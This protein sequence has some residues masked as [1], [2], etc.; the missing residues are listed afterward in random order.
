MIILAKHLADSN[1][2]IAFEAPELLAQLALTIAKNACTTRFRSPR[3]AIL[4][5][6]HFDVCARGM[7]MLQKVSWPC[8]ASCSTQLD[9][10]QAHSVFPLLLYTVHQYGES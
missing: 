6:G 5:T 7:P 9:A 4:Q 3:H 10:R 1:S 8:T 2:F